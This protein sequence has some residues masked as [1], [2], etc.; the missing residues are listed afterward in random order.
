MSIKYCFDTNIFIEPWHKHY[1]M[2]LT[3]QYWNKISNLIEEGRIFCPAMVFDELIKQDDDLSKWVK[4]RK[5]KL[6]HPITE[7]VQLKVREILKK[8][9]RLINVRKNQSMADPWVIAHAIAENAIVVTK[10]SMGFNTDIK[11]PNVCV[12]YKLEYINEFELAS[13]ENLLKI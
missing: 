10:E 5:E 2:E 9:P 1:S 6:V 4:L 13:R 3:P 7:T 11:I 8:F 12:E